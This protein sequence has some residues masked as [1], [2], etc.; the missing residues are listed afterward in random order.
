MLKK[1]CQFCKKEFSTLI[2]SRKFCSIA[3]GLRY[4]GLQRFP[5]RVE[6]CINHIAICKT[7]R[8]LKRQYP[9]DYRFCIY[10]H[11]P[12]FESL[13]IGKSL[14]KVYS[15]EEV[16][17]A[18]KKYKTKAEFHKNDLALYFCA[19]RRGLMT[20]FD[21]LKT[22]P[23]LF[24][25]IN[26][27]YRYLFKEYNAVYVGRTINPESR[28]K[29]HRT[30]KGKRT[31]IVLKFAKTHNIEVPKME[32]LEDGL[33]GEDSQSKENEFVLKYKEEGL[34]VLNKGAT[35]VG[36]GSMGMK[37]KHSR[38]K[39][40]EIARRYESL[41]EFVKAH[42]PLYQAASKYGWL[43]ECGF[44]QRKLR[45]SS[46]FTKEYCIGIAHKYTRR[47]ELA[48]NDITVYEKMRENGWLEQCDWLFS[49]VAPHQ[50][51][52]HEYCIAEAKRF[53][54]V[55]E[56]QKRNSSVLRKLY[57][58]GWI[59]ECTWFK[60]GKNRRKNTDVCP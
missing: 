31:S 59:D 33:S 30:E 16:I 8:D 18:A 47:R 21:W 17:Q 12:Q 15:N 7:K 56:L 4:R 46:L 53:T 48:N 52:T 10:H 27:V 37:R 25:K 3:C 49:D 51:L 45:P 19:L 6:E 29:E 14:Q 5:R 35:G 23:H 42:R 54:K 26:F 36:T 39:F 13:P 28:D 20:K 50:K 44:L 40:F 22:S 41:Q 24:H 60:R 11:L 57:K 38:K 2:K 34:L 1:Q 9:E 58:M 55:S 43:K 32:I